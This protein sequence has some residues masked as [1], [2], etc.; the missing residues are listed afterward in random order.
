MNRKIILQ[1]GSGAF[2]K[3]GDSYLLMK[4]SPDRKI[5]PNVWSCIGGHMENNELNNPFETCLR[6]IEEEAGIK[7]QNISFL[8]L[9]YLL[10]LQ[11]NKN[12]IRQYYIYFGETNTREFIN[13]NEGVLHWVK[14]NELL[15]YEFSKTFSEMVEHFI[16]NRNN[17]SE[18]VIVGITGMENG[19]NKMKWSE[20][21]IYE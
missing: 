19:K 20:L 21:E 12:I 18:K 6:E 16:E 11:K 10:I 7:R 14:E 13:T 5:A 3:N 2:L 15:E 8:K 1:N 9:R 17:F 4:R